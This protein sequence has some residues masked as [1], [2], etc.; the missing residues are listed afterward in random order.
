MSFT[1]KITKKRAI[2]SACGVIVLLYLIAGAQVATNERRAA[3]T[4]PKPA[5]KALQD[6]ALLADAQQL[7][8]N[9]GGIVLGFNDAP[10]A[11]DVTDGST[12]AT[13]YAPNIIEIK[14]GMPKKKELTS[15]SYEYMHYVWSLQPAKWRADQGVLYDNYFAANPQFNYLL[16][17]YK[18]DA[19]TIHDE[20]DSTLC[21]LINPADLSQDFNA[22]CDHY[23][24]NRALLF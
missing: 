24:P 15:L 3:Q 17:A 10:K 4:Q 22:Y 13:F 12:I 14:P 18:G 1:K 20:M 5:T 8:I 16:A 21:T 9:A 6:P 2:L 11:K 7:G 19:N 23:I